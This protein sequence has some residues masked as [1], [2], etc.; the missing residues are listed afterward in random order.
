MLIIDDAYNASPESM[1]AAF[2]AIA[3]RPR[4]GRRFAVLGQ[5]SE[6]GSLAQ[7]SHER[8]GRRAAE[9]FDAVAVVDT[10]L[11]RTLATAAD[12]HLLPDREAAVVW[13]KN[14]A[15]RGDL[16]LIKASHGVHLD[17][18]VEELTR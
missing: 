15:R 9:V 16:V 14:H 6:L 12:A 4:E 8:V 11:G 13:V 5:M 7:S 2:D 3:D 10:E 1:L 17:T 18:V